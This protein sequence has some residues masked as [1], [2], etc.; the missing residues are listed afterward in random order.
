MLSQKH[1]HMIILI[2]F[3]EKSFL[4]QFSLT[5]TCLILL[6]ASYN[7]EYY[8]QQTRQQIVWFWLRCAQ[9]MLACHLEDITSGHLRKLLFFHR[10]QYITIHKSTTGSNDTNHWSNDTKLLPCS[11]SDRCWRK[12]SCSFDY[13]HSRLRLQAAQCYAHTVVSLYYNN[14]HT[15]LH[16]VGQD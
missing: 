10:M 13:R 12:T 16:K 1:K 6:Y 4:F 8:L 9:F 3:T 5:S 15:S 2:D 14:L 7:H 11:L